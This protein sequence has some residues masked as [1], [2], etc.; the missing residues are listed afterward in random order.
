MQYK[1]IDSIFDEQIVSTKNGGT[2]CCHIKLKGRPE[3]ENSLITEEDLQK[4]YPDL[5]EH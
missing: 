5:L 2:Q 1:N 4:L 3:S